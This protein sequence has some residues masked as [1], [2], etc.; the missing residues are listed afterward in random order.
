MGIHYPGILHMPL[1]ASKRT[2]KFSNA[3]LCKYVY[4]LYHARPDQKLHNSEAKI[5]PLHAL[6]QAP[7][8]TLR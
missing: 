6:G 1:V 8:M 3:R 2:L 4:Q 5:D 7:N